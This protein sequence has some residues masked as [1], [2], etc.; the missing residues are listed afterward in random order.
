MNMAFLKRKQ[1]QLIA[2][3]IMLFSHNCGAENTE[4]TFVATPDFALTMSFKTVTSSSKVRC[5]GACAADQKCLSATYMLSTKQCLMSELPLVATAAS[6]TPNNDAVTY[7][8]DGK[9]RLFTPFQK[10]TCFDC[11]LLKC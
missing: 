7:S 8:M 1:N 10:C 2:F 4:N 5:V 11:S 6:G 9:C 3:F